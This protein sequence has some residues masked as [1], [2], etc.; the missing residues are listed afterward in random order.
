[1]EIKCT[2]LTPPE[3]LEFAKTF[4]KVGYRVELKKIK[5]GT[6]SVWVVEVEGRHGTDKSV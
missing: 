4:L 3:R 2:N 6:A 5:V 1:M